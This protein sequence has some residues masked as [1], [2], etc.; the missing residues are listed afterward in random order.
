M[1]FQVTISVNFRRFALSRFRDS[2]RDRL[3]IHDL[4]AIRG[5]SLRLG[6]FA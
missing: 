2:A 5:S 3:V 1:P 6:A 4:R